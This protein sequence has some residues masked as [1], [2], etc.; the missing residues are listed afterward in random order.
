MDHIT[1]RVGIPFGALLVHPA[2]CATGA[3]AGPGGC[4]ADPCV[5]QYTVWLPNTSVPAV[6]G[7]LV[8]TSLSA[9]RR[10]WSQLASRRASRAWAVGSLSQCCPPAIGAA[11]PASPA[12]SSAGGAA[13]SPRARSA[14]SGRV[15]SAWATA[16]AFR[17]PT[18]FPSSSRRAR[19]RPRPTAC[20]SK[21]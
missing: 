5:Q 4:A 14:P 13:R 16:H 1:F 21:E 6:A 7:W 15:R 11:T 8:P 18:R 20:H 12:H 17:A 2:P 9:L 3:V 19:L 10:A